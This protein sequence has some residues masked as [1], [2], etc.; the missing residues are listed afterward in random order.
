[1][2]TKVS[3]FECTNSVFNITDENNSFSIIIPGRWRIPNYLDDDI[4]DNLK[5]LLK[6]KSEIKIEL[7]VNEVRKEGN[8]IK[9][10]SKENSSSDFDIFFKKKYLK[11]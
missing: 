3:P 1:M 9:N 2:V 8:K 10:N 7:H 6:L 11:N 5:K 4:I